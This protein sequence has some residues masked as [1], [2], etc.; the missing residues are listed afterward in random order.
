MQSGKNR[1]R[2]WELHLQS[3]Y[4]IRNGTVAMEEMTTRFAPLNLLSLR[5]LEFRL[6]E[7]RVTLRRLAKNP[8]LYYSPYAREKKVKPFQRVVSD[9]KRPIDNPCDEL[10]GIQ[11]K[12]VAA[13]LGGPNVPDFLHGSVKGR[14]II[15]NMAAHHGAEVMV[16]MDIKSYFVNV[17]E[18]LVYRVWHRELKCSEEVAELLTQLTTFNGHL[19]QGAPTSS[20]LANIYLSS[21]FG[22]ILSQSRELGVTPRAYVDDIQF[23][24]PNA[25]LMMEPTRRR[26]ARD[27][28]SF[29]NKKRE[30]MGRY[31]P[32][33]VAGIRAG[34][35]GPR[36]P[37]SKLA[38]L[39]AGFHNLERG[40]VPD[41]DKLAYIKRLAARVSHINQICPKD[42]AKFQALLQ[43]L[44]TN[45]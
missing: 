22:P 43:L 27:G 11:R 39:R 37:K 4:S 24:G 45:S 15:T 28:F 25:R 29:P 16:K 3:S 9:K 17:T 8:H 44:R 40:L 26:L 23:S 12:I 5:D 14:T 41:D 31:K 18:D 10:K 42:A 30:V 2:A 1:F 32:K 19:P 21:V 35:D 34:K 13:L 38:D 36:A 6:G 7:N 33:T 20:A